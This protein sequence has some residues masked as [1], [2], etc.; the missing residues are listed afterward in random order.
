MGLTNAC[1]YLPELSPEA[2]R[3]LNPAGLPALII[4]TMIRSNDV[5]GNAEEIQTIMNLFDQ[6]IFKAPMQRRKRTIAVE[7][8]I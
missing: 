3:S 7:V 4:F 8:N 2:A 5:R 6:L 1:F